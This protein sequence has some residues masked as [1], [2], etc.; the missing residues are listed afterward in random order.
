MNDQELIPQKA[1]PCPD[2]GEDLIDR[3]HSNYKLASLVV[4]AIAFEHGSV[5]NRTGN[6]RFTREHGTKT[7][8]KYWGDLCHTWKEARLLR[9]AVKIARD[10][11]IDNTIHWRGYC[12]GKLREFQKPNNEPLN[13][14]S[15]RHYILEQVNVL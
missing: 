2:Q 15:V 3:Y 11:G 6:K 14:E 1:L 13:Y 7:S 5:D 9:I 12:I 8:Q 4:N 10:V